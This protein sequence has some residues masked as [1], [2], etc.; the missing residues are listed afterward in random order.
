MKQENKYQFV[1][2]FDVFENKSSRICD[3]ECNSQNICLRY[4]SNVAKYM[5]RN[6][7][8][9]RLWIEQK[10][11]PEMTSY[12]LTLT[13]KDRFIPSFDTA[14]GTFHRGHINPSKR[15][16]IPSYIPCFSRRDEQLFFKRL[17]KYLSKY[18]VTIKYLWC[19][20]YGTCSTKRSHYHVCL[21]VYGTIDFSLLRRFVY[22]S[23]SIELEKKN[24]CTNFISLG[25]SD[26]A[27]CPHGDT[28]A[29]VDANGQ[30]YVSKYITKDTWF[31]TLESYQIMCEDY[32]YIF[33][34]H[35]A[36]FKA[37][38]TN[39]GAGWEKL[40]N[41][42]DAMTKGIPV[43]Y[44]CKALKTFETK[45]IPLPYYCVDRYFYVHEYEKHYKKFGNTDKDNEIIV[46]TRRL[47]V[48]LRQEYYNYHLKS[49]CYRA[50]N[51]SMKLPYSYDDILVNL[52]WRDIRGR[53][54]KSNLVYE[55][56]ILQDMNSTI[57]TLQDMYF[58]HD[59]FHNVDTLMIRPGYRYRYNRYER[60][61]VPEGYT[62]LYSTRAGYFLDEQLRKFLYSLSSLLSTD[63]NSR[64][65]REACV[66]H[67]RDIINH[68]F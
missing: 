45:F 63:I 12:L 54:V 28:Y 2:D 59:F 31:S 13:Y 1:G 6:E 8:F 58:L 23:W 41:V 21:M 10:L 19:S 46:H 61:L 26:F 35:Y 57:P 36:P 43:R 24:G 9:G 50:L 55:C 17:R 42:S 56:H 4:N 64:L 25:I 27:K 18:D 7:W 32:K 30:N 38:S 11:H 66:K 48:D 22:R 52:L 33:N 29:I 14:T 5:R 40:Y 49:L 62:S 39:L 3:I 68:N 20:E 47:K 67:A 37:S 51:L 16:Y 65:E 60:D 34:K 44:Y 53:I 15:D